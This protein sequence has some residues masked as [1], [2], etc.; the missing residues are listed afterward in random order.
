M[1]FRSHQHLEDEGKMH[2]RLRLRIQ[3]PLRI[4]DKTEMRRKCAVL[5]LKIKLDKNPC[6]RYRVVHEK[7]R[8]TGMAQ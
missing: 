8:R 1:L 6:Y 7:R 3:G 2:V 5:L 4:P